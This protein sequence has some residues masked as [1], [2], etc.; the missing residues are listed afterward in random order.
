MMIDLSVNEV[1]NFYYKDIFL[2][3]INNYELLFF[4]S[5][6]LYKQAGRNNVLGKL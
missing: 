5:P 6:T 3:V 4:N 1:V 2:L